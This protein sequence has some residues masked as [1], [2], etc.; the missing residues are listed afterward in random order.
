MI[1][2]QGRPIFFCHKEMTF[3]EPDDQERWG[4]EKPSVDTVRFY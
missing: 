3:C 1:E 4:M 2:G